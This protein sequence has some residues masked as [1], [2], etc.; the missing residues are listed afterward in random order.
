MKNKKL[1]SSVILVLL[2]IAGI[3]G[4]FF[5]IKYKTRDKETK[6]REKE[7]DILKES[8][9]Q[10]KSF[11]TDV[12]IV[13]NI[14][15]IPQV[16]LTSSDENNLIIDSN[17]IN[18]IISPY[19]FLSP[20]SEKFKQVSVD[21]IPQNAEF[22]LIKAKANKLYTEDSLSDAILR[23]NKTIVDVTLEGSDGVISKMA[24]SLWSLDTNSALPSFE[25]SMLK[26]D[27]VRIFK[28]RAKMYKANPT[29][30]LLVR[31]C[32]SASMVLSEKDIRQFN[33]QERMDQ[34]LK[35]MFNPNE[36]E[37]SMLPETIIGGSKMT[38]YNL[39]ISDAKT[40][41]KVYFLLPRVVYGYWAK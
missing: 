14:Q 2:A 13:K 4:V 15:L 24:A 21:Y 1:K 39:K 38:C 12:F 6:L 29:A 10:K 9:G 40:F 22:K 41:L 8:Y 20:I 18:E 25:A 30:T 35:N 32:G 31:Y 17:Y 26:N 34:A 36:I 33:V 5:Y 3:A 19:G 16:I 11:Y 37:S 27:N 23:V 28:D 7:I